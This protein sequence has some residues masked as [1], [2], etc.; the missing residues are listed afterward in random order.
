MKITKVFE[1]WKKSAENGYEH[2]GACVR[3]LYDVDTGK[4]KFT[5]RD[6][7]R[8]FV[9]LENVKSAMF[10]R[11]YDLFC[12]GLDVDFAEREFCDLYRGVVSDVLREN[13]EIV[14][15]NL[16]LRLELVEIKKSW[17]YTL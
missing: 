5:F 15:V 9:K 7:N 10:K 6:D 3:V 16:G 14:D 13:R 17:S 2:C 4:Y 8:K 1:I 12:E 11:D